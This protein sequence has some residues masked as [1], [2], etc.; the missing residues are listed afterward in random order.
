MRPTTPFYEIFHY[1]VSQELHHAFS[2][3]YFFFLMIRP[4]PRST[5]FPYTTLFRSEG[6]ARDRAAGAREFSGDRRGSKAWGNGDGRDLPRRRPRQ[7]HRREQGSRVP[8]RGAPPPLPRRTRNPRQYTAPQ[9]RLDRTGHR[10]VA[11]HQGE[12]HARAHGRAQFH[13]AG[14]PRGESGRGAEPVVSRWLG[15]RPDERAPHRAQ[16]GRAEPP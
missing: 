7:S 12:A 14:A 16:T 3:L 8:G 4:P 10:S 5:L 13:R 11:H 1:V 9:A 2:S 15:A 6:R